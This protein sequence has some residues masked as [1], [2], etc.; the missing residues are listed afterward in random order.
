ML[1]K[2]QLSPANIRQKNFGASSTSSSNSGSSKGSDSSPAMRQILFSASRVE[3]NSAHTPPHL[4]VSTAGCPCQGPAWLLLAT[5]PIL[6]EGMPSYFK[7]KC[8]V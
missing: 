8:L 5:P 4:A 2:S 6:G 1:G 7:V 3:L